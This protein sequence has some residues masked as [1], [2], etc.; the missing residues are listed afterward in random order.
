MSVQSPE[1]NRCWTTLKFTKPQQFKT[2]LA[3]KD[4]LQNIAISM[5]DKKAMVQKT[6]FLLSQKNTLKEPKIPI[7][8]AYLTITKE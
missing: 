8:I 4:L 7:G 5:E 1:K 3:L 6:A 2:T